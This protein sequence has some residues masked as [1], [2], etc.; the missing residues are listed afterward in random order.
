[1]E[2]APAPRMAEFKRIVNGQTD[3]ELM[4][5]GDCQYVP[6]EVTTLPQVLTIPK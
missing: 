1:M 3:P 2:G 6:L 4:E 5:V